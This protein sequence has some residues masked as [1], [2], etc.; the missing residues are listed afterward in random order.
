ML[1][2]TVIMVM[3]L[4]GY[5]WYNQ[6]TA[7]DS[8]RLAGKQFT[9]QKGWAFLDDSLMQKTIKLKTRLGKIALYREFKFEFSDLDARRFDGVITHHGGAVIEIKFFHDNEI[10]TVTLTRH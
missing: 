5:Y 3:A 10:E 9:Q 8:S 1:E 7:L 2:L 4:L 6:V